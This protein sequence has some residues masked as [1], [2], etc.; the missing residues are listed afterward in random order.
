MIIACII[1]DHLVSSCILFAA[2]YASKHICTF[3]S[4]SACA[5]ILHK[6][7]DQ[8]ALSIAPREDEVRAAVMASLEA[9]K[10]SQ[11]GLVASASDEISGKIKESFRMREGFVH[12]NL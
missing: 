2:G 10:N 11:E 3:A 1:L 8:D 9:A 12:E 7:L 5:I 4:G 6:F